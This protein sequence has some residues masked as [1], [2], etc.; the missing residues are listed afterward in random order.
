MKGQAQDTSK[1]TNRDYTYMQGYTQDTVKTTNRG[2]TKCRDMY[3][4]QEIEAHN[5]IITSTMTNKAV[6]QG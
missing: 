1:M 2:Y 4:T 6:E 3:M 5:T